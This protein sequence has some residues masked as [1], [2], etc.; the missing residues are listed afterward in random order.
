M[1]ASSSLSGVLP[2]GAPLADA[3]RPQPQ[4]AALLS[5]LHAD[6]PGFGNES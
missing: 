4:I 3:T 5:S 2:S 1:M 6:I